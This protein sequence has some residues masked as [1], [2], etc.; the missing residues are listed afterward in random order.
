MPIILCGKSA[1]NLR[2]RSHM[3]HH[4]KSKSRHQTFHNCH[5]KS[6]SGTTSKIKLLLLL[7]HSFACLCKKT[8]RSNRSNKFYFWKMFI[9]IRDCSTHCLEYTC[10]KGNI[11]KNI[12]YIPYGF[13]PS[14]HVY[15]NR[16]ASFF[17]KRLTI[18]L[19]V[20]LQ[21]FCYPFDASAS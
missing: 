20:M 12:P 2:K 4:H 10:S 6:V 3:A 18:S 13:Y 16:P 15:R 1:H 7:F 11:Y 19:S 17:I 14:R 5:P 8:I 21:P 9:R